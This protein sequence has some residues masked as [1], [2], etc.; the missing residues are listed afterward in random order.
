M[1]P[2]SFSRFVLRTT[3]VE[4]AADFYDAVLGRR[5]DGIVPLHEEAIA[6]GARPHWL[7]H[8]GVRDIGGVEAV[9]ER[10]VQRGAA[11]LGPPPGV[12][13]F[14][15][16]RD[17]GGAIVAVTDGAGPSTAGVTLHQLNTS[18]PPRAAADYSTLFGWSL[19]QEL[20][21]EPLGRHQQFAFSEG[22]PNAGVISDVAGRPGVHTHWLYFF[23]VP[24]L[25][26]TLERVVARDGIVI[27]PITLPTGARIAACDDPQGA[28]FGVIEAP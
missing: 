16:L 10:F 5:G 28:A 20:D 1:A 19:T 6:R 17:P 25:D 14:A 7:G 12:G 8:V 26:R 27:G 3:A 22:E 24:S 18:N 13:D 9:A 4:A 23:S 15:V 11:R 2:V 21:L